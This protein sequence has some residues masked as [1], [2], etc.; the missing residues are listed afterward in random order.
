MTYALLFLLVTIIA[1][2]ISVICHYMQNSQE[3]PP[4]IRL[5]PDFPTVEEINERL[6]P[7]PSCQP[8]MTTTAEL[9]Q[10]AYDGDMTALRRH[11]ADI[12]TRLEA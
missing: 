7:F 5:Y 2:A 11:V 8:D 3:W 6:A 1:I 9:R 4:P 10:L 12:K